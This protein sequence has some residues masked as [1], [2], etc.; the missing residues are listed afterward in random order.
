MS[1]PI[2][3]SDELQARLDALPSTLSLRKK[4]AV[5]LALL[6][7]MLDAG[8]FSARYLGQQAL[9]QF[10][11]LRI[12]RHVDDVLTDPATPQPV[13]ERLQLALEA[14]QFGIDELGLRGG[15]EFKRFVDPGGPVAYNLTVAY[16]VWKK[17]ASL[18]KAKALVNGVIASFQPNENAMTERARKIRR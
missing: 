6:P 1:L 7:L 11:L 16:M 13:R 5:A 14:R 17:D 8:C 2:A 4:G 15:A 12:R 18:Q 10:H 9:G 3:A